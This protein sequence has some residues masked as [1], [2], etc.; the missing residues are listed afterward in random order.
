MDANERRHHALTPEVRAASIPDEDWYRRRR[1]KWPQPATERPEAE[2][3]V[4]DNPIVATLLGPKGEPIRQWR[5]RPP[6]GFRL[7]RE[8]GR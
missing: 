3:T 1:A 7:D 8:Q 5:A 4:T 6:I 2:L